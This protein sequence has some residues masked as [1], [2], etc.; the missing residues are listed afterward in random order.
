MLSVNGYFTIKSVFPRQCRLW[1]HTRRNCFNLFQI[2]FQQTLRIQIQ[3]CQGSQETINFIRNSKI[4]IA[5]STIQPKL[6][7]IKKKLPFFKEF[8]NLSQNFW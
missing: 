5:R 1:A 3:G 8:L 4:L 6:S 2:Y 7:K